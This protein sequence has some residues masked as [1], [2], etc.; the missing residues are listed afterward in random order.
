[1]KRAINVR[2]SRILLFFFLSLVFFIST[3]ATI[4]LSHCADELCAFYQF[5]LRKPELVWIANVNKVINWLITDAILLL[6][7][8][9][10]KF[11][12]S[13]LCQAKLLCERF[14]TAAICCQWLNNW[15]NSQSNQIETKRNER[16]PLFLLC[17]FW[18]SYR[19]ESSLIIGFWLASFMINFWINISANFRINLSES[20]KFFHFANR[21]KKRKPVF[22]CMFEYKFIIFN[23]TSFFFGSEKNEQTN[24]CFFFFIFCFHYQSNSWGPL[25][26]LRFNYSMKNELSIYVSIVLVHRGDDVNYR[27]CFFFVSLSHFF[28]LLKFWVV[29]C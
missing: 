27:Q 3:L 13:V 4:I 21:K 12:Q 26:L 22:Q 8:L 19:Q 6:V 7:F 28:L 17:V 29:S 18:F 24:K 9:L 5:R 20:K 10:F 16:T 14:I 23:L 15:Y 25:S 2:S 1:M 11:V